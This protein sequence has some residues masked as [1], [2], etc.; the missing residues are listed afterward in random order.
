MFS[1]FFFLIR[2]SLLRRVNVSAVSAGKEREEEEE[3]EAYSDLN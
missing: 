2:S 1:S 3:E